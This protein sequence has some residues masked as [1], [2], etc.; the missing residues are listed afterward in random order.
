VWED[1]LQRIA[2][3]WWLHHWR[4]QFPEEAG[5][6]AIPSVATLRQRLYKAL[7]TRHRLPIEL[8]EKFE[9]DLGL[10]RRG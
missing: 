10:A 8:R 4:G 7:Q 5:A 2:D 3:D 9:A 6:L 1:L